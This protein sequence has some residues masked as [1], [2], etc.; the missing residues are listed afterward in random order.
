MADETLLLLTN[1]I[2][3]KTLKLLDGLTD[4]QARFA[5]PGLNNSILWH[6]GHALMVVEHLGVS[7]ASGKPPAYP[8]G[9]FEKFSWKSDPATVSQWPAIA[10]VSARLRDQ[11]QRLIGAIQALS[12]ERLSEIV[13]PERRRTLRFSILH[14][15]HDEANHQGEMFL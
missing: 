7:P 6:A 11:L 13:D 1:E 10:E 15:L 12:P 9:W 5:A 3:N 2:R 4:E 14:G 8:E